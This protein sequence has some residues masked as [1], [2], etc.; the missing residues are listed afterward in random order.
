MMQFKLQETEFTQSVLSFL[1]S[2]EETQTFL[3]GGAVRDAL[4]GKTS[5]DLDF[6]VDGDVLASA[7][8]L[9]NHIKGAFYI[10][11]SSRNYARVIVHDEE[12]IRNILDFAPMLQNDL[13]ADLYSRDF[14][15]NAIAWDISS[16]G[17]EL[18]DPW[19]GVSDLEKRVLRPCSERSF[20][21][22]PV[23]MI[24][25]ARFAV[26]YK[27]EISEAVRDL[28]RPS[29][30][31]LAAVSEERKRDEL[32]K[33]FENHCVADAMEILRDLDILE[34]T[35]PEAHRLVDFKQ[36]RPHVLDGWQ[37]T[38]HALQYCE[39]MANYIIEG[40]RDEGLSSLFQDV[41]DLIDSYSADLK[42]TL[43]MPITVDRSLRSLFLFAA[44]YH[45]IGKPL[46]VAEVVENRI[47]YSHHS[48]LGAKAV[49]KRA[50]SMALSKLEIQ[51]L[52]RLISNHML[53]HNLEIS[54]SNA[55]QRITMYRFFRAARQAS[56]LVALFSLADLLATYDDTITKE[57]WQ[58]GLSRCRIALTG[59]FEQY[60]ELVAPQLFLNGDE[61]QKEFRIKPGE[62]L[63]SLLEELREAQAAGEVTSKQQAREWVSAWMRKGRE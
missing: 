26:E 18:I 2:L 42:R 25:A 28:I 5:H 61:L 54:S 53:L 6:I 21:A 56:P 17:G 33:I 52:V 23:R 43:A 1:R 4:L 40:E 39:A 55:E 7:R 37:H 62:R 27:M 35:F 46:D 10:L 50:I 57:R 29:V 38:L 8:K 24:R 32:L 48:E 47:R 15:I 12:G 3:V 19:N 16:K 11:D 9:A 49:E 41:Y 13:K 14:T 36:G 59:W 45:D 63:G 20:T 58:A 22:D 34:I 30:S 60:D 31:R 44:F 51:W